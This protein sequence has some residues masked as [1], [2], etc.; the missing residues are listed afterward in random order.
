M[1]HELYLEQAEQLRGDEDPEQYYKEGPAGR[2]FKSGHVNFLH[3]A[4]RRLFLESRTRRAQ[5]YYEYLRE[6]YKE[7]DGRTKEM[8]LTTLEEFAL[9]DYF[10]DLESFRQGPLLIN[11][12]L[13]SAFLN[14]VYERP[15]EAAQRMKFA[16]QGHEKYMDVMGKDRTERRKILP[17]PEFKA[18][19]FQDFLLRYP[20]PRQYKVVYMAR[21][22]KRVD[23]QTRLRV[24]R[25]VEERLA[26]DCEENDP[27]LDVAKAFPPP[28]GL[29]EF[30]ARRALE[31]EKKP[32]EEQNIRDV[33]IDEGTGR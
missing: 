13:H 20:L 5:K 24:Y 17:W 33:K 2:L 6:N 10:E 21:A 30:E 11:T 31:G 22:W 23:L 27:R 28:P 9:L 12:M 32:G 14:L 1:L 4:V 15:K 18:A 7:P 3:T 25:Q 16:R 26:A 29:E 19:A 8:Y